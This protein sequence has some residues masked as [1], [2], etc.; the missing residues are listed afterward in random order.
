MQK[1]KIL[2]VVKE[3]ITEIGHIILCDDCSVKHSQLRQLSTR[4]PAL[5]LCQVK[6]GSSEGMTGKITYPPDPGAPWFLD[7]WNQWVAPSPVQYN[8]LPKSA[9]R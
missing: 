2:G 4:I 5:G 1:Q 6:L 9:I 3:A 7:A 8:D